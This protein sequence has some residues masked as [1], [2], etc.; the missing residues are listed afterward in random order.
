MRV[1][2]SAGEASGDTYAAALVTRIS[3]LC[4]EATFEGVGGKRMVAVGAKLVADSTSWGVIG[5]AMAFVASW[6][7]IAGFY[8]A[9]RALATGQ[10]GLFV[11]IDFGFFNIKLARKAK[12]LGWKVA[13]FAPPGSWRRDRQG[14]DLA[15]VTDLVVTQFSWSQEILQ[16]QGCDAVW[17][18]H[19]LKELVAAY[20]PVAERDGI[21]V[22]PGSR[23]HEIAANLPLARS[24][25][26]GLRGPMRVG[27]APS[28]DREW[29]RRMWSE[30]KVV[31]GAAEA[32]RRSRAGVVCSGTATLEAALCKCP[33][34]IVYRG[35][36]LMETE[37]QIRRPRI[38]H[39][40][41]PNIILGRRAVPELYLWQAT[42]EAVRSA[43][44]PLTEETLDRGAQLAAFD[45]IDELLGPADAIT[46]TAA[47]L[48]ER[49]GNA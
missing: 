9:E 38:E 15:A 45:E 4:P 11:P 29:V 49:F 48:V 20:P 22:L 2:L 40:G 5:I 16:R 39:I 23:H 19:P 13:Y 18:G 14:R 32:L 1:F 42:P 26:E 12:A 41:L 21:A 35:N 47:L 34:V 8:A 3:T 27:L 30:A 43:L 28:T 44:E 10:P 17:L 36:W 6:N 46:A 37:A 33:C 25:T 7:G 31:D 24:A